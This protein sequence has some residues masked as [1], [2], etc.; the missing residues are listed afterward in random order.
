MALYLPWVARVR[1]GVW[2]T[3]PEFAQTS[4]HEQFRALP[5]LG[6]GQVSAQ[7]ANQACK[8]ANCHGN[9]T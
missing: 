2:G 3:G 5:L 4:P 6:S 8:A 1:T 7:A 9:L